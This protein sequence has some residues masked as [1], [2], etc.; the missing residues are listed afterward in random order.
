MSTKKL[1]NRKFH[2]GRMFDHI[3]PP[4]T[5]EPDNQFPPE[6]INEIIHGT[7]ENMS[8]IPN[9]SVHLC[10]TSPPYNAGMDYDKDLS[11]QEYTDLLARVLSE[12]NRVLVYGG[13]MCVN[14][15][16]IG[17]QP[18]IPFTAIVHK[19]ADELGMLCR[20]EIIWVKPGAPNSTMW[21]SWLSP[22][23]PSLNDMHEY[24]LV[25]SKGSAARTNRGVSTLEK[26][27]FLNSVRSVWNIAPESA[28]RIGHPAPFPVDIPMRLI[29]FYSFKGEVVL[30]PF[31]GS[32][33]TAVAASRT[34]RIY[35]GYELNK[36]YVKLAEKRLIP[37]KYQ[38]KLE[39]PDPPP[40]EIEPD[41]FSLLAA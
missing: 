8:L 15:A 33:T 25:Y 38:I 32:G 21:G 3:A 13:R 35:V 27:G 4:K 31:M 10:V 30:D 20:G 24:I 11:L 12:V 39:L 5:P 6:L 26:A 37:H 22:V 17:R 14:V 36:K 9:N 23:N 40:V 34:S 7:A 41:F 19:I 18:Y 2:T 16:N 29:N 28:S 1:C